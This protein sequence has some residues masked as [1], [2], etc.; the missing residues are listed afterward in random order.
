MVLNTRNIWILAK[1]FIFFVL[2]GCNNTGS[3]DPDNQIGTAEP[4]ENIET[5]NVIIKEQGD[6][7]A[8]IEQ[9]LKQYKELINDQSQVLDVYDNNNWRNYSKK[10]K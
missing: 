5:L 10:I 7:I 8:N 2:I 6:K 4:I 1:S 9:E 3:P